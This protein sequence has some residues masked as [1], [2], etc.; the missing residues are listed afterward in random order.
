MFCSTENRFRFRSASLCLTR[1]RLGEIVCE[2]VRV[3]VHVSAV[4]TLCFVSIYFPF[5]INGYFYSQFLLVHTMY[6][7]VLRARTNT[8]TH[9]RCLI[10]RSSFLLFA[11]VFQYFDG[12]DDEED[13]D[14]DDTY[15]TKQFSAVC[16]NFFFSGTH[17]HAHIHMHARSLARSHARTFTDSENRFT[18]T[19]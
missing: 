2:R 11:R 5:I 1:L 18:Q 19:N 14:D 10:T 7:V 17:M 16:K 13:D 8:Y 6:G 3:C 12:D 15:H 4:R 9:V